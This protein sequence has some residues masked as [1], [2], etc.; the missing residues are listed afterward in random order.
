M[1]VV[2]GAIIIAGM[3]AMVVFF[4]SLIFAGFKTVANTMKALDDQRRQEQEA[5]RVARAAL[6]RDA[7]DVRIEVVERASVDAKPPDQVLGR[8]PDSER[9]RSR[10][11]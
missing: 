11:I 2:L 6:D 9:L 7:E 10:A 3:L 5:R 1:A 4:Y 8:A